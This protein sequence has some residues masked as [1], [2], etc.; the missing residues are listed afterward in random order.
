MDKSESTPNN[1]QSHLRQKWEAFQQQ[2]QATT[3]RIKEMDVQTEAKIA[4]IQQDTERYKQ[5]VS[6][7][8]EDQ[9]KQMNLIGE[10][11]KLGLEEKDP[12]FVQ[13]QIEA[14]ISLM[15]ENPDIEQEIADDKLK[16]AN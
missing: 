1:H 4:E 16:S 14:M 12:N 8:T 3:N 15:N 7:H 11:L 5:K 6:E 10:K 9:L 2:I 13:A